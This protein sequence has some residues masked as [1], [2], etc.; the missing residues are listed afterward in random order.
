MD[1]Q[2][3]IEVITRV[4]CGNFRKGVKGDNLCGQLALKCECKCK[5]IA[6]AERIY[7]AGYRKIPE[8]AV[9]L[10]GTETEER[11]EDLLVNFDEMSFFPLTLMPNPEQCAKEW[12]SKLIYAIGQLRKEIAEKFAERLKAE[13]EAIG[14]ELQQSY[15]DVFGSDLPEWS[16]PD[17]VYSYGYIDKIDEICEEITE[18]KEE[19]YAKGN[20]AKHMPEMG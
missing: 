20:F 5:H 1:K 6:S 14:K 17:V 11:I 19:M 18:G 16:V 2:K 15:D 7:N 10:T 8:N 4:L 3:Q 13:Y 12:K 9:V